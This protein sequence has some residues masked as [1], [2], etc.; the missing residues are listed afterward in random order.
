[1]LFHCMQIAWLFVCCFALRV[2]DSFTHSL[3]FFLFQL[4]RPRPSLLLSDVRFLPCSFVSPHSQHIV[5]VGAQIR[6]C[7]SSAKQPLVIPKL[8]AAERICGWRENWMLVAKLTSAH[9]NRRSRHVR[10]SL[11]HEERRN[12][13]H[14]LRSC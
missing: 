3:A 2:V 6:S 10:G 13:S 4:F 11:G 5:L 7:V 8:N 14:L 12:V 1:M 9:V